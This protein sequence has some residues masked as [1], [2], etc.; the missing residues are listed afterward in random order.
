MGMHYVKTHFKGARMV[1]AGAGGVDHTE[2]CQ[3]ADQ[4]FGKITN[5][6]EAEIP[7]DLGVRYTGSEVRMRDDSM[8]FAH[9]AVGVEGCGFTNP[10][11]FPLTVAAHVLGSYDRSMHVMPHRAL[12]NKI[13]EYSMVNHEAWR[14]F[15]ECVQGK[16]WLAPTNPSMFPT[17]TQDFG[18]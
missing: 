4:H 2:L 14:T 16:I 9:V 18:V 12:D 1:L 8:P 15:A 10:D 6:Y 13:G 11:Y 3:L 7:M 5:E 17:K